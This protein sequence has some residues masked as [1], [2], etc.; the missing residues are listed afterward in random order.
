MRERLRV[1]LATC[2]YYSGLIRLALWWSQC[3]EHRLIIL[4]YHRAIG[5]QLRHQMR[6]LRRH[7]R[8]MHLEEALE[9]LYTASAE[10]R[11][12]VGLAGPGGEASLAGFGVSPN[13]PILQKVLG[14]C[15]REQ[16]SVRDRRTPL[17]LT[18]DDG[19]LDN[20]SEGWQLARELRV[21]IT[22]FLLPG[23]SESGQYF[24]WLAADYLVEHS[25]VEKVTIEGRIYDLQ[26]AADRQALIQTID[27]RTRVAHSVA[28]R[29]QFLEMLQL[30]LGVTLPCRASASVKDTALPLTWDEIREMAQ[31]GWVSF[32][33]H[34]MHHPTLSYLTDANELQREVVESRQCLEQKLGHPIRSF[35]YPIGKFEHIGKNGLQAVK[36]AGY[37]WGLSTIEAVNTSDT[38]PYLLGRLPGDERLNWL[39]MAAEL[40]GLLGFMSR[41]RRKR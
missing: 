15:T 11:E 33:A 36:E 39:V 9:E 7:Y 27:T 4:N 20:Y 19:Y 25:T 13:A 18:F 6:Y 31:S 40:A 35:A 32:G 26:Q 17:V 12:G 14:F 37:R 28:E 21:P 24:W 22:I 1:L 8:I 30:A 2:F 23:Y 41:L 16:G 10:T 34:T 29:E 3:K 5:K 38:D